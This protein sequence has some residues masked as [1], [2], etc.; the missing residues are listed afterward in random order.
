MPNSEW[1]SYRHRKA[2]I[3]QFL[4]EKKQYDK[5]F[6][7][8]MF[9]DIWK[10]M[11]QKDSVDTL[12]LE[13]CWNEL[14]NHKKGFASHTTLLTNSEWSKEALTDLT[15]YKNI[16]FFGSPWFELINE[17][18]SSEKGDYV[19]FMAPHNSYFQKYPNVGA[20][21]L[22]FLHN[23]RE[24]TRKMDLKLILKTRQ[25]YGSRLISLGSFDEVVSDTKPFDHLKLYS[26]ARGVFHFCSSALMELAFLEV[27]SISI[28]P[29]LYRQL[30][31]N[32][33]F[34]T[35]VRLISDK[36]Y[37]S[38]MHD[39]VHSYK[40]GYT[41]YD[42][43]ELL[44]RILDSLDSDKN[45]NEYKSKNFPGNHIGASKRIVEFVSKC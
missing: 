36:Y 9:N 27:P 38:N 10:D 29:E 5:T 8:N 7:I 42:D 39:L 37:N 15:E 40:I 41:E 20:T 19:V 21:L 22:M 34:K 16:K 14:Y 23:L 45:W 3:E 12:A 30:H 44:K 32:D 18:K 43:Y 31:D 25:K 33:K 26:E 11:Y 28:Y 4:K 6:G 13:Y 1:K 24:Y 35:P 17:F 2:L